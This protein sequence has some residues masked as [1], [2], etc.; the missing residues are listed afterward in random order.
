MDLEKDICIALLL[1]DGKEDINKLGNYNLVYGNSNEN[2]GRYF[3]FFPIKDGNVLTVLSSGDQVLQSV[4]CGAKNIYAFDYN[5]LAIYMGK[6]KI[7]SLNYLNYNDFMSYFTNYEIS[8]YKKIRD[9]LDND[10]KLFWDKIYENIKYKYQFDNFIQS[11][12]NNISKES[13]ANYNNYY[14]TQ[15]KMDNVSI[16]YCCSDAYDIF[17]FIPSNV[18][19]DAV[20]LSNIFDW[21]DQEKKIKY[22]LFI[23]KDLVHFMKDNGMIAVYSSVNGYKDTPLDIIF[24]DYINVDSKNRVLVYKKH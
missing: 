14:E 21:M 7:C 16:K 23:K 1:L 9:Y 15:D 13:Y 8:Y 2:L 4:Y 19:F 18:K 5:P 6:L 17:N 10:T 3:K 12:N 24:T 20:F 22:P 11:V